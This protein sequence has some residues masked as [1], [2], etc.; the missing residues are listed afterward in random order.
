MSLDVEQIVLHQLVARDGQ[1]IDLL[2]RATLLTPNDTVNAITEE[3]HWIYN[4]K[5]KAYGLFSAT[6]P[7]A[8][9]IRSYRQGQTDFLTFSQTASQ[10]LRNELI[11]YPFTQGGVVFFVHYRYMAIDY[12]LM[13]LLNNQ[14]STHVNEQL[15]LNSTHCLDIQRADIVARID[16]TEWES[17]PSSLRYLTF[18]RGRVGRKVA[19]FFMDFLGAE[20]GLD[21]KAQNR[22][23]IQAVEDYCVESNLDE[24]Q[25]RDFCQQAYDYCQ[26][27]LKSGEEI[28]L[29]AFPSEETRAND[30]DFQTFAQE[31]GYQLADHFPPD[32]ATLKQLTKFAGSGGGITLSFDAALLNERIFWDATTDTLTIKTTPPNLREQLQRRAGSRG[33]SAY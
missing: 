19:D 31:Q 15:E 32:R 13:A 24:T 12:L 3:L 17:N 6:S 18:L 5:S 27:Q 33:N 26:Q 23:L 30:Q 10:R 28:E 20:S 7:L 25:R 21:T 11:K 29:S 8:D 16:L 1:Q 14:Q 2:L 22:S 4:A 9:S